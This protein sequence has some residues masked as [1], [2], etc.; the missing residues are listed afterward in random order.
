[1]KTAPR[2][3]EAEWEVMKVVWKKSPCL[4]QDII[5]SLSG[6]TKWA[7]ATVKTLLNRL[8]SKGALHFEKAGKSYIYSPAFT[9]GECRAAE[10]DSFLHRVFDGALSPMI[11]HL[12]Q[13]RR[14]SAK[15]LDALE[16]ILRERK[17]TK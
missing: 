10:A 4:A 7:P 2:I 14:L 3:S 16:K 13:S 6:S 5:Q 17:K 15:E 11:S 9:E 8:M 12:V 1:M